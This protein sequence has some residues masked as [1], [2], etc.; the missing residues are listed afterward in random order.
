MNDTDSTIVLI[1]G[2]VIQQSKTGASLSHQ[3]SQRKINILVKNSDYSLLYFLAR[4]TLA[5]VDG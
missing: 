2:R 5:R 1:V 4:V 3:K